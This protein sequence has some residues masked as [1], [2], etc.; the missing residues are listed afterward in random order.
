M[1]SKKRIVSS[2]LFGVFL[3][4]A[5]V[6]ADAPDAKEQRKSEPSYLL[7]KNGNVL[8]GTARVEKERISV[9]VDGNSTLFVESKQ[10]SFIGP[11]LE[12]IY[13][14]QRSSI[15]QWGTGEHWQLAQ[16]CIQQGLI[17]R[18][19]EHYE[20]LERTAADSP[21]FKQLEQMLRQALLADESVKQ[22]VHLKMQ[23]NESSLPSIQESNSNTVVQ[24][25]SESPRLKSVPKDSSLDV[26][27]VANGNKHEIPG[28]IKKTF[29]NSILPVLVSKCGQ[30][31]CHGMLGK[32][33][34][35]IYQPVGEQAAMTL[36]RDLDEVLR[37]I[38][39][40]R[41]EES[42]LLAYA[43]KA[44]GIQR[45]PSLNP[46]RADERA[47]IERIN[48]WVKSLALSQKPETTMPK[49]YPANQAATSSPTVAA[50]LASASS[51]IRNSRGPADVEQDRN[52]KLSKP[53]RSASPT[54]FLSMSELAE[55]ESAI[56]KF[57]KQTAGGVHAKK[58]PFDPEAFNRQ[59]R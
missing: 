46:T 24:A 7:L 44:H 2:L 29:E 15:R 42:P 6:L 3:V 10:V 18:A 40:D 43:T 54:A 59:F 57:E 53:A 33:D 50:G 8:K 30:S 26:G 12:S 35:H 41:V 55:L 25:N 48:F 27:T 31:G 5:N 21:R 11:T 13:Q 14:H 37:Y 45:N 34:F 56:E 9:S 16:W 51:A 49:Q 4:F 36:S 58:D 38:E 47:L 32:S 17:D 22:A 52:A 1:I 20:V 19:I 39:R 23:S 28:Y